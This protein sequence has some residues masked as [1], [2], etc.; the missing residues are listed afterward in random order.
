MRIRRSL[1]VRF[2]VLVLYGVDLVT[3]VIL[4]LVDIVLLLLALVS[5]RHADELRDRVLTHLLDLKSRVEERYGEE[6]E[7]LVYGDH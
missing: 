7:E 2:L 5:P 3:D 4:V 6:Y 1:R